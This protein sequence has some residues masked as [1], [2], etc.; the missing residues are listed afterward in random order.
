MDESFGNLLTSLYN[1]D[2]KLI[3]NGI[4]SNA[5]GVMLNF[6]SAQDNSK[7]AR[8]CKQFRSEVV[9]NACI[10]VEERVCWGEKRPGMNWDEQLQ[11]TGQQPSFEV[12]HTSTKENALNL[13][14]ELETNPNTFAVR[15]G[16]TRDFRGM[17]WRNYDVGVSLRES[18][19]WF[20]KWSC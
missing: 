17:T 20:Y 3:M 5:V 16:F 14:K 8:T 7:L 12:F 2:T 1:L 9:K 15:A 6:L 18:E 4:N 13:A 10:V 19:R 11:T